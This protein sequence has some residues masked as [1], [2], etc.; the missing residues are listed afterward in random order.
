MPLSVLSKNNSKG[1]TRSSSPQ[2]IFLTSLVSEPQK[3]IRWLLRIAGIL[4]VCHLLNLALGYP[5]W[6]LERLFNLGYEANI[7]TWFASIEW[8]IA[9]VIAYQCYQS[10]EEE[11]DKRAWALIALGLL[12]FSIDETA[13]IHENIFRIIEVVYPKSIQHEIFTYFKHSDW[14]IVASPFLIITVIWLGFTLRRLLKG[15]RRAGILL[16]LG[17]FMILFGGWGLEASINFLNHD[18]LQ[19]VLEI[20][21]V[22]E[23]SLEMFGA[24]F[25]VWG[26]LNHLQRKVERCQA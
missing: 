19:W 22:F 2:S 9:A 15:S 24:I 3:L 10:T 4:I 8:F 1:E 21:N 7:P 25:I 14:P 12:A 5:S 20:E 13:Q 17:L 18:L 26:L 23:E 11:K 6:Q 16:G